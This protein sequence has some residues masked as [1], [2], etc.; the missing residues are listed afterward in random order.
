MFVICVAI[1]VSIIFLFACSAVETLAM[2]LPVQFFVLMLMSGGFKL[3][4]Y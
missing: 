1:F 2:K 3:C 4:N